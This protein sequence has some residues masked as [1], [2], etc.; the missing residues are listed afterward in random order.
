MSD[1]PD[2]PHA[3]LMVRFQEG[4]DRAFDELIEKFKGPI[5]NY[6]LRQIGNEAE[7][8]DIAQNVFV[9]VYKS[10]RKYKPTAKF[11]TWLFTIARNLCLNEFRRRRRHPLQSLDGMSTEGEDGDAVP[12]HLADPSAPSP[13]TQSLENERQQRIQAAIQAL[14]ENQRT[15]LLLCGYE[16]LPYDEIARVL[17]TS[18]SATK[19]LIHRARLT[20]K[21]Q[22][23]EFLEGESV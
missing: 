14:P 15:A 5:F 10:A 20:L 18:V 22:L 19:S 17:D 2:D 1:L 8:E 23:R 16:D 3:A 12:I 13:T 4:E 7:A 21:E 6:V 11:T 9:Q